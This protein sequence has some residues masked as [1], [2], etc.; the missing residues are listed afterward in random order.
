MSGIGSDGANSVE[1]GGAGQASGLPLAGWGPAGDKICIVLVGSTGQRRSMGCT[2]AVATLIWTSVTICFKTTFE[3]WAKSGRAK[4]AGPRCLGA[5]GRRLMAGYFVGPAIMSFWDSA[6]LWC[7]GPVGPAVRHGV[8]G[9][10]RGAAG[11]PGSACRPRGVGDAS[12]SVSELDSDRVHPR[13]DPRHR[14]RLALGIGCDREMAATPLPSCSSE[15]DGVAST[16][17]G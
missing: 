4:E 14:E 9:G 16:T 11:L 8:P 3:R 6:C 7:G 5:A 1:L 10:E 15:I 13:G 2:L 17:A 12:G